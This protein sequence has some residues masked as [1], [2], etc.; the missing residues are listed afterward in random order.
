MQEVEVFKFNFN[1][2][3]VV[4]L[5]VKCLIPSLLNIPTAAKTGASVYAYNNDNMHSDIS[6]ESVHYERENIIN[7]F[8]RRVICS[9]IHRV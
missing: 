7:Q 1:W 9:Y 5:K 6:L 8:P 4:T 2:Q 3:L